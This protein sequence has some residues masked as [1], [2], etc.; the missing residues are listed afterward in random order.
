MT[1]RDRAREIEVLEG[2]VAG[3]AGDFE[4]RLKLGRMRE[5]RGVVDEA[6]RQVDLVLEEIRSGGELSKVPVDQLLLNIG[7]GRNPVQ[8]RQRLERLLDLLDL[9][10]ERSAAPRFT[11]AR[12]RVFL[13]LE[14]RERFLKATEEAS[15]RWPSDQ[16]HQRLS[17]LGERWLTSGGQTDAEK[18][19]VI[20]LSRT[21]TT[22]VHQALVELG[23]E[24]IHWVN[25]LTGRLPGDVDLQIFDAFSDINISARF[26]TLAERYPAARFVWTQRPLES[27]VRSVSTHYEQRNGVRSPGELGDWQHAGHFEGQSGEIHESLYT[28]HPS[29]GD[30]YTAFSSRV[31]RYFGAVSHDR[32]LRLSVTDGE[33]W[34]PL[35]RFLGRPIPE[36]A[37]PHANANPPRRG[38]ELAARGGTVRSS[39]EPTGG[40]TP[41]EKGSQALEAGDVA[42]ARQ[43]LEAALCLEPERIA[44]LVRLAR[45]L[46]L[47]DDWLEAAELFGRLLE[48][49]PMHEHRDRWR[50][51]RIRS[52]V[53]GGRREAASVELKR[54]WRETAEGA[55]YLDVVTN[56][57][58]GTQHQLRFRH[59]LIVTYG[60]TGSTLLQGVLNSINGLLLRGENANAFYHFFTLHRAMRENARRGRLTLLPTAPWF[61]IGEMGPDVLMTELR[62]LARRLLLG[63][64]AENR[65]VTA[66]GF[67]EI[68]YFDVVDDLEDYL[69]FLEQLFPDVAFIFNTRAHHETV[70]SAWWAD[71]DPKAM[72]QAF[73]G[74]DAAFAS[75]A[76]DRKNCFE[77]SYADVVG[78]TARLERL[79]DFLGAPF[80][81]D[82][83]DAVL[84]IPHSFK[85]KEGR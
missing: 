28:S 77:I 8:N 2:V 5:L 6:A 38:P 58:D 24:G 78:R 40:E 43:H 39:E 41:Y 16:R 65:A 51:Q 49:H 64:E 33:G 84:A 29:W 66:L 50:R 17:R 61:G 26:E 69:D 85:P 20:G 53:E 68:R 4:A 80:D 32:L 7:F 63:S 75:Y 52:L 48:L 83:I 56:V 70:R 55:R 42:L 10:G 74:L 59:V 67:K 34:D 62:P 9:V 82:R 81:P 36:R 45:C 76:A 79:F 15:R 1:R 46:Q 22:S 57:D 11:V 18:V 54:V 27:W 3:D 37:F 71:E 14:D 31:E 25:P 35:C 47:E 44:V 73:S 60:R 13:A 30:A 19:F 72:A 21:G 23:F 12:C